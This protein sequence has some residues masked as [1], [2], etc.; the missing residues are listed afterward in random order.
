MSSFLEISARDRVLRLVDRHSFREFLAPPQRIVSPHLA[1]LGLPIA[2]DDGIVIGSAMIEGN[3]VLVGAQEGRF[4]GG[5]VGEI[6]GAKLTGLLRRALMERPAAV[7]LLPDSGGVRL[8]EANAGLTAVAEI[9]RSLLQV[10]AAGV[11]VITAIGGANGCY[12]GMAIALSSS[13]WIIM[14][15]EGRLSVSGPEV[16]ETAGGVEEFD[17]KDRA[18]TWRTMGGKHRRLTGDA[19][20]L[21]RDDV[22]EFRAAIT[23]LLCRRRPLSVASLRAHHH[24]L[25]N[26]IKRFGDCADATVYWS[27]LGVVDSARIPDLEADKF[28]ELVGTL[29]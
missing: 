25:G 9:Q 14:S 15:E 10:R 20:A 19:V 3:P 1:E 18:L 13:D 22:G 5:S 4:M 11:T 6:H 29:P 24:T 27:R 17:S 23:S 7:V 8:Q 2:F 26:R 21:V 12:G 16:I 28:N